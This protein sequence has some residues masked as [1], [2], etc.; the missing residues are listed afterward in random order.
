MGSRIMHL[1]ISGKIA[2]QIPIT[3]KNAFLLGGI[4]PDA[5][6]PKELSHFFEGNHNDF[7]RRIAYEKFYGKYS[8]Y[9]HSDYILGYYIH[10]IADDLWLKGFYLP[11]LKNRLENDPEIF[12]RYH[13]DFH[14]LNGKLLNHYGIGIDVL[15]DLY[16]DNSVPDLAEV[17]ANQAKK[18]LLYV[19]EDMNYSQKELDEKLTVFTF[20]QILG[21]IE[22]SVEKSISLLKERL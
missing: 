21:Y 8:K 4:A 2:N 15:K 3:D 22:T 16:T 9:D 12:N 17:T 11:W 14:L 19:E 1:I 18:L 13:H 20:E 6:S 7:S 10:L 5:V